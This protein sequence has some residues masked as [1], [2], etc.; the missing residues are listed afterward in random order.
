[1]VFR[2]T[3]LPSAI[4][5]DALQRHINM[6]FIFDCGMA[7]RRSIIK[8]QA[9]KVYDNATHFRS[10]CASFPRCWRSVYKCHGLLNY[11]L[12]QEQKFAA[13]DLSSTENYGSECCFWFKRKIITLEVKQ[14]V[15]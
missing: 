6:P 10:G 5:N 2:A 12:Y 11:I 7:F 8:T 4:H 9:R 15:T 1:M 13:T 14:F 3:K